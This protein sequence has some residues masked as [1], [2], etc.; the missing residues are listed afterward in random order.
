[1]PSRSVL[2][3]C[4]ESVDHAGAAERGG[5]DRIE[6]CSDL[7]SGGVTPNAALMRA[8]RR[9]IRVPVHVLIRPRSGDFVYSD[10]EFEA[11]K[12]DIEVAK[13]LGMDGIVVGLLDEAGQVDRKRTGILVNLAHPL[14]VTFH[15]AFDLSQDLH[16]SLGAVIQTGAVRILTSG[17]KARVTDGLSTLADLVA[18]AGDR[19]VIMPGGSIRASNVRRILQ[20]TGAREVHTSL[21]TSREPG[22]HNPALP[23]AD[24]TLEEFEARVR[25]VRRLI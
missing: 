20:Q 10:S 22:N 2:E 14:P 23:E 25:K 8:V 4:V 17:G 6:F 3:I 9:G 1:M 12:R 11:M 5:A 19:I 24:R 13:D 18:A 21:G 16:V 15:R 7:P